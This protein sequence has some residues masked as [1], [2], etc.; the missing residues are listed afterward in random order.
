M[1]GRLTFAAGTT[2][3]VVKVPIKGDI[4]DEKNEKFSVLLSGPVGA[5][6]A[7]GTATGTIKDND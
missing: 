3:Q 2:S 1:G 5:T 4:R 6:I 7:D